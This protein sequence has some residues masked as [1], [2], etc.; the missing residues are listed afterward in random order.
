MRT[1][2]LSQVNWL[3]GNEAQSFEE[4]EEIS[5]FGKKNISITILGHNKSYE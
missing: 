1:M 4:E 3:V 5:L 2:Q